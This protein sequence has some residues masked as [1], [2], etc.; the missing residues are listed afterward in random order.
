MNMETLNMFVKSSGAYDRHYTSARSAYYDDPYNT[1]FVFNSGHTTQFAFFTGDSYLA[2]NLG[3]VSVILTRIGDAFQITRQPQSQ[4]SYWGK[5]ASFSVSATNGAQPY[6]WQWQ[7]DGVSL[8]G[9]TNSLLVL[10]N[11][12]TTNAGTYTVVV[13][14]ASGDTLT[15]QPA[16]LTVNPAG[17]SIALYAGVKI[18]GVVGQTYGVQSTLDLSNT[19]SWVGAANITLTN[20]T[21]IWYDSQPASQSQRYY[22]VG[23][24][25]I[26]IP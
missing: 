26:S 21:Q 19:N 23:P 7:K 15:S 10:T 11:L 12:Q 14:E 20:A 1:P 17:V 8:L 18:D 3:G 16:T 13:T 22:R 5:A 6:Q 25:P 24:G 4:L 9:A 2:D